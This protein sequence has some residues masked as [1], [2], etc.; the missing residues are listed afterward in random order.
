MLFGGIRHYKK[1]YFREK[2]D[3]ITAITI[4][5]L[6]ELINPRFLIVK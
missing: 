2:V 5:A 3:Q 6:V 4:G 1:I